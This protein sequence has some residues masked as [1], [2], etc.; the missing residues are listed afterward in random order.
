MGAPI[1]DVVFCVPGLPFDGNTLKTQSLGGSESA[2]LYLARALAKRQHRVKMFCG[3]PQTELIDGVE[4]RP[5]QTWQQFSISAVHD[6]NIVQ[7]A[8][9]LFQTRLSSKLNVL[10]CHDLAL[11]RTANVH[12]ATSWNVDKVALLS[13]FMVDQYQ[14]IIGTPDQYIF[15]TRNGFDFDAQPLPIKPWAQ[16]D[17]KLL[18]YA[19]RPER[20]LDV[21]VRKVFPAMLERDPLLKLAVCTYANP[22]QFEDGEWYQALMRD[23]AANKSITMLPA[24]TKAQLYD[25]MNM[26]ALY[27]YPTPGEASPEFR[28]VS[29]I[30]A[31]EAQACG[32]PFLSTGAGA[33]AETAARSPVR[34]AEGELGGMADTALTLLSDEAMWT[35]Y[36]VSQFSHLKLGRYSWDEVAEDWEH[37]FLEELDRNNDDPTRLAAWFYKR[38][39]IDGA[40]RALAKVPD[41]ENPIADNLKALIEEKYYFRENEQIYA[42]HYDI[43]GKDT[44]RDLAAKDLAGVFSKEWIETNPE[45]RFTVLRGLI[46]EQGAEIQNIF[47]YGCGHGWSPIYLHNNLDMP[48]Y[49]LDV[50]PGAIRWANHWAAKF[51]TDKR[52][53]HFTEYP[54]TALQAWPQAMPAGG[55]DAMVCS[56]VLEHVIDPYT[57]LERGERAV[58]KNGWVFIT[59]PFGPWEYDGPNWYTYRCHIREFSSADLHEMLGHKPGFSCGGVVNASHWSLGDPVGFYAVKYRADHTPVKRI[60]WERKLRIQRP[61]QTLSVNVIAGPG[62]DETLGWCLSSVRH[63]ADEIVIGDTGLTEHGRAVALSHG[64]CL[65]PAPDPKREGFDAARNA[66]LDASHGEW[67]LWIDSD[68]RLIDAAGVNQFL[69]QNQFAGYTINQHHMT[70]DSPIPT[71]TP[72]RMFRTDPDAQGRKIR[73]RGFVHEHPEIE[74]NKGPGV[75]CILSTAHIAHL[76]YVNNGQRIQRFYRNRPLLLEDRRRNPDRVL[77]IYLEARDNSTLMNEALRR[78][79]GQITSEVRALA[80]STVALVRKYWAMGVPLVNIDPT[81]FYSD[82]LRVLGQGFDAHVDIR[83]GREGVGDRIEGELRF[84]T[85]DELDAHIGRLTKDKLD[86]VSEPYF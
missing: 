33:L 53:C 60:D 39:E 65:V 58:K 14:S 46:A 77:G 17:Q 59:V 18:L 71:D 68:E 48:V 15:Q 66:A 81:A 28:E 67:V 86:A 7:R 20:G 29:C 79:N 69:R 56:E 21:L 85:R 84:A 25:L 61:K 4:Y 23:I 83:I 57:F 42:E 16:R 13:K 22:T 31:L 19:A 76:G 24:Q 5:I 11:K 36:Q 12:K 73:F 38:S 6:I 52:A 70:I 44:D 41:G 34:Q 63:I 10:W 37:M 32:L 74:E 55:Y 80:E 64:A 75:V 62:A 9:E 51:A 27:V 78:S 54:A 26:A 72:V 47:D 3:A 45:P 30:A 43:L 50:D 40:E 8:P 1:L 82:A 49:G 35:D 2:G